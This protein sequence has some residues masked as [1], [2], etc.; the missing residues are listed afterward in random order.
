MIYLLKRV[1]M[2]VSILLMLLG[3]IF[4]FSGTIKYEPMIQVIEAD[5]PQYRFYSTQPEEYPN[6]EMS[7]DHILAFHN[8]EFHMFNKERAMNEP[9]IQAEVTRDMDSGEI[10]QLRNKVALLSGDLHDYYLPRA[11]FR[12]ASG[13]YA[14]FLIVAAFEV[15]RVGLVRKREGV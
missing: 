7:F 8:L 11:F 3:T 1:F 13:H 9:R 15:I 6:L 14:A 5:Y 2:L 12:Y 10:A 4:Y